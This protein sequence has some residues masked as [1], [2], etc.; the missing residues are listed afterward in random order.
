MTRNLTTALLFVSL[1]CAQA[2]AVMFDWATIGYPFNADD[3]HGSGYGGV[4][5]AFRIS[6]HEVTNAQYAQFLNTVD[7]EGVNTNSLYNT[8]MSSSSRGGI[9]FVGT[10]SDGSKYQVKTGRGNNPVVYVSFFDAMRF[11]NWLDNG[12]GTGSTETGVYTIGSGT[13][14]TRSLG[15]TF[16]IPSEDEWYKAAYYDPNSSTYY[17]FPTGTDT[18]SYSDDPAALNTPDDTNAG[19]FLKNDFTVNGYDDGYAVTGTTVFNNS[20]NYLTDVGAYSQ[21]TSPYGTFDQG[22]NVKEWNEAISGTTRGLRG[23]SWGAG[24]SSLIASFS[25]VGSPSAEN[26]LIGFRVAMVI[27]EPHS[28]L[29]AAIGA[30]GLFLRR[31]R[32][33]NARH[34]RRPFHSCAI[35]AS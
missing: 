16:F 25:E 1:W 24:S 22:G 26:D 13:N 29:L 9:D 6:R 28:V 33:A 31:R 19:N 18:E 10:A 30:G 7:P 5:Y 27:P 17:D 34:T 23:G 3:T 12:Q 20:Q 32:Q 11:V 15:A 2:H 21:S 4:D 35:V 14:E 8:S